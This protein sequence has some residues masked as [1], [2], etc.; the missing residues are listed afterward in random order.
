M[1]LYGFDPS[2]SPV[3]SPFKHTQLG[4]SAPRKELCKAVWLVVLTVLK[5]ISQWEGLS[6]ILWK[7][8]ND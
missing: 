2:S 6:H 7:I 5:H 4:T 1:Y 8:K 3:Q